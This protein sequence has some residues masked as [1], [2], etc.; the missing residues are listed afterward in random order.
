MGGPSLSHQFCEAIRPC[1]NGS[2]THTSGEGMTGSGVQQRSRH[3]AVARR[4]H[5]GHTTPRSVPGC[6]QC[7]TE[8]NHL[9]NAILGALFE[10]L[11]KKFSDLRLVISLGGRVV[12]D[13][14]LPPSHSSLPPGCSNPPPSPVGPEQNQCS[15]N[16]LYRKKELRGG[17]ALKLQEEKKRPGICAGAQPMA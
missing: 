15:L 11:Q 16:T 7:A 4:S 14:P 10:A 3:S 17:G 9:K 2:A 12:R 8:I 13:H 5:S 1:P 6:L